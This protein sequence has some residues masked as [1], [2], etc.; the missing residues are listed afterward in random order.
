VANL[1]EYH[2]GKVSGTLKNQ[3]LV[4]N[5]QKVEELAKALFDFKSF[6]D[7]EKWLEDNSK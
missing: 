7:L 3:I 6:A 2:F 5:E 4:L 1:L